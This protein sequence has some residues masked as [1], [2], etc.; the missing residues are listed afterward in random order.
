M[1][2]ATSAFH[3][4]VLDDESSDLTAFMTH[5]RGRCKFRRLPFGL[6]STPEVFHKAMVDRIGDI[7]GVELYIDDLLVHDE[8]DSTLAF[9]LGNM[10]YNSDVPR[11]LGIFQSLDRPSYDDSVQIQIDHEIE[12][13]GKGDMM[14][15]LKGKESWVV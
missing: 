15:L 4:V 2:D 3:S 1:L 12:T 7:D 14:E 8:K 13:K 10:T 5:D 11:P 9:I 6:T